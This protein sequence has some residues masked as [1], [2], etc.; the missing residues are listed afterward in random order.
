M[1]KS[2]MTL[3]SFI[4]TKVMKESRMIEENCGIGNAQSRALEDKLDCWIAGLAGDV[5][6]VFK[7]YEKLYLKTHDPEY[8]EYLRLKEKFQE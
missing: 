4:I 7:K 6:K 2:R 8:Q 5:P 1:G 3:K